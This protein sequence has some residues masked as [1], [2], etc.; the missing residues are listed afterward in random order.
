ME[1]FKKLGLSDNT[2]KALEKKGYTTPTTIQA[3]VIPLLLE[4]KKDV[5]GQSQT[6]TGKTAS[7]AL[8]ILER[9]K[10]NSKTVQAIILT[11]TRE[12]AMQVAGEI[13]SLK[14]DKKVFVLP[15]YGGSPIDPQIKQLKQ[16]VDIVVGT[17]G[18]VIDLQKRGVLKLNNIQYAVLDE[19]DEMLNMGFVDDIKEILENSPKEKSMLLFSATMPTPIL[20]IAKEYM[21]EHEIIEIEKSQ[22]T[23]NTIQQI[24]YDIS[25]K[26]R[27]EGI[28]RIIDYYVDF[29]G[30]IFCNTKSSVDMV[31]Q[32]LVSMDYS[33]ASLHGDI[34]QSQ[35][36]KIL[37]QFRNKQI[38]I[39]VATDVAAR[40]IDVNDLS[41]VINF[42]LPQSPESYVH[43]IG[44]TG[45]AGKTGISITLVI[46]SESRKLSLL[47]K[48][49]N[50]KLEKHKLPSAKEVIA[51]KEEQV[52]TLIQNIINDDSSKS[53]KY[54]L[55]AKELL[56]EH[57][58][59]KI[60]S[61][62]LKYNFKHDLDTI[63]YKDIA[64]PAPSRGG[65]SRSG[66]SGGFRRDRRDGGDRRGFS[67]RSDRPR[68]DRRSEGRSN[69]R[70]NDRERRTSDDK[71]GF[72]PRGDRPQRS[73][74]PSKSNDRPQ[75]SSP[76]RR[77][78]QR[79]DRT[80]RS[81]SR[82]PRFEKS[83]NNSNRESG[84]S[85]SRD[86][87]PNNKGANRPPQ[88]DSSSKKS[89]SKKRTR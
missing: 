58:P 65:S 74:R 53:E 18:R 12:L 48:V 34:T 61:A 19:A 27:I 21:K 42:S 23:T 84:R 76:D 78:N 7:F 72:K 25:A 45:R 63:R 3:R 70:S 66:N 64:E 29:Y 71:P 31:T 37:Q 68:G 39:L 85:Q 4:G 44:R 50:C 43:R 57:S 35:R 51:H 40:G 79:N 87:K 88:R 24:Y 28:R 33:A 10:E 9:I 89:F 80:P 16:G 8:P 54:N 55:M 2:V 15:I 32:K 36:E 83:K 67:S 13:I 59:M 56:E 52:K 49:N 11:P 26:D 73:D 69:F 86:R 20:K 1:E 38:N 75:R 5:V 62:L 14:G 30:I 41:H 6:G 77:V 60:V 46:P 82:G 17:P 22:I 47:E 81:E